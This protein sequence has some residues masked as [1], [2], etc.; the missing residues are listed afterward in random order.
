ML[1]NIRARAARADDGFTLIELL[2]VMIIIGILAAIAIPT[3]LT[4]RKN[5]WNTGAKTDVSN[6]ALSVES[7][8][9]DNGN[10][11]TKTFTTNVAD[12]SLSSNGALQAAN[13]VAGFTFSGTTGV[14]ITLGA[15]ATKTAFCLVGHNTNV[16]ATEGWWVWSQGKGGLLPTAYTSQANADAAC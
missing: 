11:Y 16:P 5:G 1:S 15:V 12:T 3:F 13:I 14:N 10:D 4:Q 8:G 2:V 9:V 7:S 6:F